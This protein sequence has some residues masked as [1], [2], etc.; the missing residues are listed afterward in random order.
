M[1]FRSLTPEQHKAVQRFLQA[2]TAWKENLQSLPPFVLPTDF[3]SLAT[4]PF[5]KMVHDATWIW[6]QT[7][8]KINIPIPEC[9][10]E[11]ILQKLNA[12]KR[13]GCPKAPSYK[14]WQYTLEQQQEPQ[15]LFGLWCEKGA[16]G[17]QPQN[18]SER[19]MLTGS[20]PYSSGHSVKIP[21]IQQVKEFNQ[22]ETGAKKRDRNSIEFEEQVSPDR[23]SV[24]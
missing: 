24:V 12:R 10:G 9:D 6:N 20:F 16:D 14:V 3:F 18:P 11:L 5:P 19:E 4:T 15:K 13:R 2:K 21:T 1:L 7:N 17:T 8:S 22:K 23:K